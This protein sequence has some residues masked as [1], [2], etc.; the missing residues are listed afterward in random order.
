MKYR[1]ITATILLLAA[2]LQVSGQ[3]LTDRYNKSNPVVIVCSR[4]DKPYEF[5]S[6]YGSPEGSHIDIA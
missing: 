6:T 2:V 1:Y 5:K 3:A 4:T